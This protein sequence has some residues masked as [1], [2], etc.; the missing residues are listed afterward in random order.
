MPRPP[1]PPWL[2]LGRMGG[3][4]R[5]GAAGALPPSFRVRPVGA[6]GGALGAG[7]GVGAGA[8]AAATGA[9]V[10]GLPVRLTGFLT[11]TVT[12]RVRPCENFGRTWVASLLAAA[13]AR[14]AVERVRG[15]VG[16]VCSF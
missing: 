4:T 15:L 7:T 9:A 13:P 2:P 10:A 12:A 11:S 1:E 14:V 6:G 5:A 16:L 8:G 3:T